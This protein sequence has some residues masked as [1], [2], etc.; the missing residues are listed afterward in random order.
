[1]GALQ[2]QNIVCVSMCISMCVCVCLGVYQKY[3][4]AMVVLKALFRR[5]KICIDIKNKIFKEN[6]Y[7]NKF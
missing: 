1:M 4:I 2:T 3:L 6:N 5:K 7:L